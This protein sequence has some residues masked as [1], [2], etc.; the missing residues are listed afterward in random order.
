M[1]NII[2]NNNA[3]NQKKETQSSEK[4]SEK[5]RTEFGFERTVCSCEECIDHCKYLPGYLIPADLERIARFLGFRNIVT[6]A[7]EHLLASSGATVMQAGRI[8]RIPTLVP[9]RKADGTC[10]FLDENNRCRIHAVSPFGCSFFDSH[11]SGEEADMRSGFGLYEI[12]RL[13]SNPNIHSYTII[14]K[15]LNGAGSRAVP[16]HIARQRMETEKNSNQTF[17]SSPSCTE[18]RKVK[19]E[20]A[21]KE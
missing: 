12:A 19:E 10:V 13:W 18:T 14:W 20:A 21:N 5:T 3:E 9:R 1:K 7:I 4:P 6:F 15:I 2:A 17:L 11:Q 8:F 16:A